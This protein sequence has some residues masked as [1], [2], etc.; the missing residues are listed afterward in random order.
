MRPDKAPS[1]PARDRHD[2]A[3]RVVARVHVCALVFELVFVRTADDFQY[4]LTP[5]TRGVRLESLREG[6]KL[7]CVISGGPP[8]VLSASVVEQA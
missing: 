7:D 6:Q 1:T 3:L 2:A 8:R 4:A 5:L